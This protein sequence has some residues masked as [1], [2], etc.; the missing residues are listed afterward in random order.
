MALFNK[1]PVQPSPKTPSRLPESLPLGSRRLSYAG[2]G[3][4]AGGHLYLDFLQ[5][6]P[7][8]LYGAVVTTITP[9]VVLVQVLSPSTI[10][11]VQIPRSS[12]PGS[13]NNPVHVG[14]H[15]LIGPIAFPRDSLPQAKYAWLVKRREKQADPG[16]SASAVTPKPPQAKPR[17]KATPKTKPKPKP[18]ATAKPKSA[19]RQGKVTRIHHTGRF[20]E[21][22]SRDGKDLFFHVDDLPSG[23]SVRVD[24]QVTFLETV[25]EKGWKAL[26]VRPE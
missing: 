2:P 6:Q 21:I 15:L 1:L 7:L 26:E 25:N 3:E 18:T 16:K 17:P 9:T 20:G 14:D 10:G 4:N 5:T 23:A 12:V 13:V 11:V 19:R 24:Q 22:R 8:E